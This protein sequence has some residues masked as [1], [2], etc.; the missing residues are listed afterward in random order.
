MSIWL[1]F[2]DPLALDPTRPRFR[3]ACAMGDDENDADV[4]QPRDGCIEDVS[5]TLP[6]ER[7]DG[8]SLQR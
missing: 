4:P 5:L 6:V 3:Y 7:G 8:A 2:Q 1:H